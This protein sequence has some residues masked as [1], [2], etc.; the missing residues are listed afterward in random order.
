[1]ELWTLVVAVCLCLTSF[2]S[3]S[4]ALFLYSRSTRSDFNVYGFSTSFS[5]L[6][7]DIKVF[8]FISIYTMPSSGYANRYGFLLLDHDAIYALKLCP[9][10][11]IPICAPDVT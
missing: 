10:Y 4:V 7:L 11:L 1:M 2:R 9:C 5:F 6:L 3:T 8:C